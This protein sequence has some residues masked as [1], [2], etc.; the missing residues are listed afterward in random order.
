MHAQI[1]GTVD[2]R[3][4]DDQSCI[5]RIRK[6]IASYPKVEMP[7][8]TVKSEQPE[9]K[10]YTLVGSDNRK[11]YDVRDILKCIIDR[12]SFEEYKA[13]YGQTLVGGFA[14]I[15]DHPVGIVASQRIHTKTG[16]G[17][18]Q[19]GSVIYADSADKAARFV[20]DCNQMGLPLIFFQDVVG[21]MVG[22]AA[23]ESGI[24][25]SG[26]KLVNAVSNSI[27]P[28]LTVII[29]NSFGAGNYALCGKA[30][31]PVFVLAWPNAKYAV[32]GAEQAADTLFHVQK[33]TS[34]RKGN[35][36]DEETAQKMRTHMQELYQRQMD[37]R[38][39]AARGWIDAIIAPHLTRKVLIDLVALLPRTT[40]GKGIH[41]GVFQV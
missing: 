5:A 39:G 40:P 6:L 25:R 13:E 14:K 16:M 21:F 26:A 24:I 28:K 36:W 20:L 17:E 32:M 8:S 34:E 31:D 15:G 19:I 7:T 22:K 12:G 10:L 27:V 4:K 1:S 37:I 38:H 18:L 2:F 33:K 9:E 11:E 35:V 30:Y 3:E 29:G 23:E 41:T